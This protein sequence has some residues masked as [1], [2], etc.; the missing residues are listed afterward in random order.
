MMKLNPVAAAVALLLA[1]AASLAHADDTRRSYIVQ[2][3]DKPVAA[4]NGEVAG[5]AATQPAPGSRLQMGAQTVQLYMDYLDQKQSDVKALVP[6]APIN[7]DYK[8]VLNG[9]SAMLTDGEVRTLQANSAVSTITANT[10]NHLLTNYTPTFL[11][12]DGPNGLWAQLGGKEHAGENIVIGVVD[13]GIWPENPS[14]ADRVDGNGVP[15]FDQ[16]GSIA[17]S[18]PANWNGTCQTGEGFTVAACNNKLIGARYF[19]SGFDASGKSLHWTEFVSPR[20]SI[21]GTVGHGGHG[22]HTSSTAGGNNGVPSVLNGIP[23]GA[24][25]GMAPRA[26]IAMYKVCWSYNDAT[27]A[28]GGK[29]SCWTDDSVAA[30]D[31]AVQ[32]GVHVINYSISG[33]TTPND[34]VEQAFLR[35]TNAGVFVS[36]SAGNDGPAQ[37]VNHIGP[38]LSTIAAASHNRFLKADVKLGSGATYSGASLNIDALPAG[39]PIIRSEDAAVA[40]ANASLVT[41][42]YSA[43]SN[44][45]VAVLDPAKVAGK[46]VTCVR[47]T[48]A[49]VDKSLAVKQAGGVGMVMVDNGAGLVAEV[50]SVPTVHLSAADGALVKAY[51]QLANSS[52]ALTHFVN[53][54][55][56]SP[57]PVIA[58]FSSRGPNLNDGNVLKPDM[59]APGVDI[60]AGV[61]PELT[62]AQQA[63]LNTGTLA[64]QAAWALYQGTSMAAPHVAG[65]AALLRQQHPGWSPAAIKSALMTSAT[66][67]FADALAGTQQGILPWAQGA[68]HINPFGTMLHPADGKSYNPNGATDPGLVYDAGATDYKKYLCGAGVT[69]QCSSGTL[70]GYNLN[71]PSITLGNVLG[72]V[73]VSRSVT[74]VGTAQAT[75]SASASVSGYTTVVTPSSLS[76]A[77]GATGSF[78]VKLTRTSA[79]DNVW[80]YGALTWTDGSHIVRIPV[81]ARSG[82]PITAPALLAST[83]VTGNTSL[84]IGTGFSGRM[85]VAS[86]GMK[87]VTKSAIMTVAEAVTG[88][89]DSLDQVKAACNS[90]ATGTTVVPVSIA[91][92]TVVAAFELFNA[93]TSSG[94]GGDDL[95]LAVL[96]GGNV[97]GYSGHG[98][99]NEA[100]IL[101]SPD[102]GSYSVCVI[103]YA[104][105]NGSA[106]DFKLSSAVVNR[107][108]TGGALR[109]AVPSQVYAASTAS[110]SASWSGLAAGT[111]YY[112]GIQYLGL[113][114]SVA[115]TTVLKVETNNPVPLAQPDRIARGVGAQ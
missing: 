63:S 69:S 111:R 49:R 110:V 96:S 83:K 24:L 102:A 41:L 67:T 20:D 27:D 97:V 26:R 51:A 56:S 87:A 64:P 52:A 23:M 7:H 35:A 17:Y 18:A 38:W 48:N 42:C 43:G 74:N 86:G 44:G 2:L 31:R 54:V 85:N 109:V 113:D 57:A 60:L 10:E 107:S 36:A 99:A 46:I 39:T 90:G 40:G 73:T 53:A 50:H 19:K 32:D 13:G 62:P 79:A 76:L 45:G 68:G 93:D 104:A 75:Y 112:G 100:V 28:T 115:A 114:S 12:L 89:V 105:A 91:A 6:N 58:N 29:N 108:D 95:D 11:G 21:G 78:T 65:V 80:Q 3:A 81:T 55:G 101:T 5:L 47:G 1:G 30:I 84:S 34:A 16:G 88:T 61:T 92:N 72:N 71:L 14:Y 33:G 103:G 25:S 15:T 4:Y 106:T 82:K 59:A 8:V 77:P 66:P 9:F 22:T 94:N 98:G 37:T 70:A